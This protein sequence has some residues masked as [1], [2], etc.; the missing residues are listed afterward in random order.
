MDSRNPIASTPLH[1]RKRAAVQ[2]LGV[3]IMLAGLPMLL[4]CQATPEDASPKETVLFSAP[5]DDLSTVTYNPSFEPDYNN[6]KPQPWV[7][8]ATQAQQDA[9]DVYPDRIEFPESMTEVLSW[10]AGRVV[11]GAPSQG[12][13]KNGMGFARRVVSVSLASPKIVVKTKTVAIED[14]LQ[15]DVQVQ[16]KPEEGRTLDL[17]KVDLDWVTNNLYFNDSDPV[18]M[19]GEPLVDDYSLQ[20]TQL[21]FWS[22][23]KKAA[24]SAAKAVAKAAKDTYI[25]VTPATVSGSVSLT[26]SL[27]FSKNG[28]LFDGFKYADQAKTSGGL[29]VDF[30]IGGSGT[31]SGSLLFNP[32]LQIGAKLALPGHNSSSQYW[33]NVD[34]LMQ[35]KLG[36]GLDLEYSV[37]S[38]AGE[39]GD[40]LVSKLSG[41]SDFTKEVTSALRDALLGH[42]DD[43]PAGGWK[44]TLYVSAPLVNVFAAGVVP[45]AVTSTFQL[46]LECGFEAKMG[47]KSQLTFEQNATFKFKVTYDGATK[48][49]TLTGPT[50]NAARRFDAQV[51]GGGELQVSC[52]LI[53]RVNVFLYDSVG[54]F[55]GVRASLVGKGEYKSV[56]NNDSSWRPSA[57]VTVG[58]YANIGLQAGTRIQAP[59]ASAVGSVGTVAGYDVGPLELYTKEFKLLEKEWKFPNGLGVCSACAGKCGGSCGTCQIGSNCNRNSDCF[60]SVCSCSEPSDPKCEEKIC[61]FDTSHDQVTDKHETDVDCGGPTSECK[62]RCAVGRACEQGSD[63]ASGFCGARGT[64]QA[65]RCLAQHCGSGVRDGDEGGLDCGGNDCSKC[66]NGVKVT[67]AAHCASGLWNGVACVGAICDDGIRTGDET[68]PDCGGSTCTGRCGFRQGCAASSDCAQGLACESVQRVCLR[69]TGKSCTGHSECKSNLCMNGTC[70]AC[71]LG[72]QLLVNPDAEAGP[73]APDQGTLISIPG[74]TST[75]QFTVIDY[76]NPGGFPSATDAGP[77]VRGKNF[78]AGGNVTPSSASQ[79]VDLSA[80]AAAIDAGS[81]KF[82]FSGWLG[83]LDS[84]GDKATVVAEFRNGA[85]SLGSVT[86]GPVTVTDRNSIT[87]LL[88]R[89]GSLATVPSGARSLVVTMT[90][91]RTAGTGTDGYV[92]NLSAV[93]SLK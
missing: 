27:S 73:A 74:W 52:G 47:I 6:L 30:S 79:T 41:P 45:V 65:N 11:V 82:D 85:S 54:L 34:S 68:G 76:G 87:G 72:Q 84:Q 14:L 58:L 60:A 7:E 22:S 13:G 24:G 61:S 18:M 56:C 93:L 5:Q 48:K 46:D 50:I 63:C 62:A 37:E 38:A 78:F 33:L 51:T 12:A 3:A 89:Q 75:S 19:P 9:A 81:L 43:A 49:T 32:G 70:S 31:Y 80:C 15:G 53:P 1:R 90:S 91:T 86:L 36:M 20:T 21:G 57:E 66:A 64:M 71:T 69:D 25:A 8:P 77:P 29:P 28:T 40:A 35:A 67:A 44:K 39:S 55:A 23:V 42:P 88:L 26:K 10:Q 92:D 17:T 4:S 59:G 83:G 2:R 16:L